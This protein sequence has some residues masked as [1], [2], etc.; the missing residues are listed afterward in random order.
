MF[1]GWLRRTGFLLIFRLV[2][3]DFAMAAPASANGPAPDFKLRSDVDDTFTSPD[4]QVRVEQ[5]APCLGR[6]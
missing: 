5:Y 2:L 6:K 4:H 3:L 1:G